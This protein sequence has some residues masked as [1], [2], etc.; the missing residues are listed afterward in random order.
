MRLLA[1][2][3]ISVA[4]V[5]SPSVSF[6]TLRLAKTCPR[7]HTKNRKFCRGARDLAKSSPNDP[8]R[9][10]E[11]IP[12][13]RKGSRCAHGLAHKNKARGT[14]RLEEDVQALASRGEKL[15]DSQEE[16]EQPVS[17][18]PVESGQFQNTTR[19]SP[20]SRAEHGED[21]RRPQQC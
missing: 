3:F 21:A 1:S 7:Q 4:K 11:P 5:T 8:D 17:N 10:N 14:S 9:L 2:R 15:C 12:L 18:R 16:D 13:R 20:V 6:P 19:R